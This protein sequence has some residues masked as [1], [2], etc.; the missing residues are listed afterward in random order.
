MGIHPSLRD[1]RGGR[2]ETGGKAFILD[3][4]H[5]ESCDSHFSNVDNLTMFGIS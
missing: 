5:P 3:A 4:G 2:E 1:K